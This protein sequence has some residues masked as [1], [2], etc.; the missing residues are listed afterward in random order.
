V[1]IL[2]FG[3][4]SGVR[5]DTSFCYF[6][7]RNVAAFAVPGESPMAQ[8]D[9]KLVAS[10]K[11][12]K[13]NTMSFVFVAK[14]NEGKLLVD[15]KKI[16]PKDAAEA[17]K[18]CGGGTIYKGR[19]HGEGGT[20]LFEVGKEVP[21]SLP[22]LTKKI[23]KQDAGLT[24]DVEYRVAADLAAEE[25]QGEAEGEG[26]TPAATLAPSAPPA[27]PGPQPAQ[28]AQAGADVTKR[29]NAMTA[30]IKTALAGPNKAR[31]QTLFV[32]VN[33]LIKTNDFVQ[34]GKVLDELEPLLAPPS[35][36]PP[37][38]PAPQPAQGGAEVIKRLN[39]MTANIKAALAGPNK[40]RVQA[41]FVSVNGLIKNKDF[42]AAGAALDELEP[43]VAKPAGAPPAASAA[44]PLA[45]PQ[46]AAP[47]PPTAPA[48]D[49]ALAAEWERRVIALEPK[50]LAAQKTRASEAKWMTMFMSAQDLGSDGDFAKSLVILDKLE[51]LLSAPPAQ[52]KVAT[53]GV[54]NYAKLLLRWREAQANAAA[55]LTELGRQLLSLPEVQSDPRLEQVQRA[56]A[57]LPNLIPKFGEELAD[58]LDAAAN[59]GPKAAESRSAALATIGAY[60]KQLTAVPVL[61]KLG[62]FARKNLKAN[63]P[64]AAELD[65][66]LGEVEAALAAAR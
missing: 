28:A 32:S 24:F 61:A 30:N 53:E 43:L 39:G 56:A 65:A 62:D 15:K 23:I 27:P 55:N 37:P 57:G 29:L 6:S 41:L 1:Y 59:G 17:K 11:Q 14:G 48:H 25:G 46:A 58:H 9:A 38:A 63:L 13:T 52:T 51:G 42:A 5:Q 31:V 18:E 8:V 21:P 16:S 7:I 47:T 45:P 33:G 66:A 3:P 10:L 22:T 60:R 26:A 49:A 12:A 64:S 20:L 19:C 4:D 34:A 2:S 40:A 44:V 35:A 36:P 54:V 50:V